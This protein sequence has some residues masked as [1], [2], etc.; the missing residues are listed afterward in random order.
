M[1]PAT[2]APNLGSAGAMPMG[3]SRAASCRHSRPL[4]MSPS[5]HS[6]ARPSPAYTTVHLLAQPMPQNSPHKNREGTDL[7][8]FV[9]AGT[10]SQRYMK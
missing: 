7:R 4:K 5:S 1:V 6:R 10:V 3:A 9:P 8:S 2:W